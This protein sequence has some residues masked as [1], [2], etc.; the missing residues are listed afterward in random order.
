MW[1]NEITTNRFM[2]QKSPIKSAIVLIFSFLQICLMAQSDFIAEQK[3][4]AHVKTAYME[5]EAVV[6][7]KLK[8]EQISP[9]KLN[10]LLVA[11]KHEEELVLYAKN[12]QDIQYKKLI[13]YPI[14]A[15]S[16]IPGPKRKQGDM[17]V[18]EGFY[19][20]SD[21]NPMSSYYLSLGINYPNPADR[22]KSTAKDPGGAIIIHGNC[23]TIGCIPITDEKIKE[24]YIY[25]IQSRQNGQMNIPVYI[26]P[27]KMTEANTMLFQGKYQ[28]NKALLSFWENLGT[29]FTK[30]ENDKKELKFS[31]DAKGN[32]I[33]R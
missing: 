5:K 12:K 16:G 4:F 1:N 31:Y 33:F 30:F 29:G 18:P 10:I 3:K 19:F 24:L 21:F 20:V 32:Y 22:K 14:C 9:D 6:L 23:V 11:Y 15:S 8:T 27:F 17:Q 7:Q 26:F 2:T 13:T 28:S 25:A